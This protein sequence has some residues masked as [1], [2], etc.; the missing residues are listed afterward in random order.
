MKQTAFDRGGV[1]KFGKKKLLD[2]WDGNRNPGTGSAGMLTLGGALVTVLS[3]ATVTGN[4]EDLVS[5]P[6]AGHLVCWGAGDEGQCDV[7]FDI[8]GP[9]SDVRRVAVG[10]GHSMALLVD[11]S[12]QCRGGNDDGRCDVPIEVGVPRNPVSRIAAG[13]STFVA[14]LAD[15]SVVCWGSN[16]QGQSDVADGLERAGNQV[17]AITSSLNHTVALLGTTCLGDLDG[18]GAVAGGDI[19]VWLGRTGSS[20][21][22]TDPCAGDL[23]GDGVVDGADLGVLRSYW[24]RC[25]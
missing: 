6:A 8:G 3:I 11:G 2:R 22:P 19:G 7:P 15:G 12:V 17:L 24:G 25:S 4:A 16:E 20:C 1:P 14:V 21:H 13:L 10:S 18:D 23:T 9:I 5:D